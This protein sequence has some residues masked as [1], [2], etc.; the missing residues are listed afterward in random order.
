MKINSVRLWK[1]ISGLNLSLPVYPEY[2][3]GMRSQSAL[4]TKSELFI[5]LFNEIK[6][7]EWNLHLYNTFHLQRIWK[8]FTK[9]HRNPFPTDKGRASPDWKIEALQPHTSDWGS[10]APS[11]QLTNQ[12]YLD[13]SNNG[14]KLTSSMRWED[15]FITHAVFL[16]K[17]SVWEGTHKFD[18]LAPSGST[19]QI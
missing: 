11:L 4:P 17:S 8:R 10:T 15:F 7:K 5:Y 9:P 16:R 18:L 14:I 13:S 2:R 6:R 19:R 3:C 1:T 12:D